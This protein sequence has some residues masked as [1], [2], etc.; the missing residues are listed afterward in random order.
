MTRRRISTTSCTIL[1]RKSTTSKKARKGELKVHF[2]RE[3]NLKA[4][5]WPKKVMGSSEQRLKRLTRRQPHKEVR[6]LMERSRKKMKRKMR[7][8]RTK[9]RT[10]M[11]MTTKRKRKN[12]RDQIEEI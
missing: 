3:K 9:K 10:R 11:E 4:R 1:K 2:L 5:K 12:K 8:M 6:R 7:R